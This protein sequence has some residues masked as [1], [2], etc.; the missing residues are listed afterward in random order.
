MEK[1]FNISLGVV[2]ALT[3]I[4]FIALIMVLNSMY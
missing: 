1:F 3:I 4:G 2:V